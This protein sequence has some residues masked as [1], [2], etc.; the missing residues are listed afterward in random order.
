MFFILLAFIESLQ[1]V[2]MMLMMLILMILAKLAT[3]DVLKKR[4]S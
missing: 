1:V 3:Q 2:L 4:V